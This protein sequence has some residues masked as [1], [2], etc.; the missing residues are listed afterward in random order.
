MFI[1]YLLADLLR[2][3]SPGPLRDASGRPDP[4]GAEHADAQQLGGGTSSGVSSWV[5]PRLRRVDSSLSQGY[6]KVVATSGW[7][8]RAKRPWERCNRNW[9]LRQNLSFVIVPLM[10][11][12]ASTGIP[13]QSTGV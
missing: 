1:D 2:L 13:S 12:G 7:E 5:P 11:E 6:D 10:S 4:S 9:R 8:R 3:R